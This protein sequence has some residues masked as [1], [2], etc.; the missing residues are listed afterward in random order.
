MY[1]QLIKDAFGG[2]AAAGVTVGHL[3]DKLS[4][5]N[6]S[7][8]LLDTG[9]REYESQLEMSTDFVTVG[10]EPTHY[11]INVTGDVSGYNKRVLDS[12]GFVD[13]DAV[14]TEC[15]RSAMSTKLLPAKIH[16]VNATVTDCDSQ[17]AFLYNMLVSWFKAYL[18]Q[19]RDEGFKIS[20]KAFRDNHLVLP[21]ANGCGD[22]TYEIKLGVPAPTRSNRTYF[23]Q[24]DETNFWE[25]PYVVKFNARTPEQQAFYLAHVLGRESDHVLNVEF[26]IETIP[27]A[28]TLFESIGEDL[29]E[30]VE[31][32]QV[33]WNNPGLLHMWIRDYVVLNRCYVAYAAA[34]DL[35]GS[36][37][38]HP[39]PSF[40]ESMWWNNLDFCVRLA[41]FTPTRA[42]IPNFADGEMAMED[43]SI[44][45]FFKTE[46]ADLETFLLNS[47]VVNYAVWLG[48]YAVLENSSNGIDDWNCA[49][50]ATDEST[51]LM[52]GADTRA[53]LSSIVFDRE[54]IS[55]ASRNC[56]LDFDTE[57]MSDENRCFSALKSLDGSTPCEMEVTRPVPYVSGALLMGTINL[58]MECFRHLRAQQQ[59]KTTRS[60]LYSRDHLL[61]IANVYRLFG[62]EIRAL[63][64]VGRRP[65]T[66]WANR[67][68]L[69]LPYFD[70][71][72]K[73]DDDDKL[74][75][76]HSVRRPG[77][78][79][80]ILNAH[81]LQGEELLSV[82][83]S[84][85]VLKIT[86]YGTRHERA[87]VLTRRQERVVKFN[88]KV[89]NVNSSTKRVIRGKSRKSY[90][91]QDFREAPLDPR[92]AT[93]VG[94][95]L[96][97]ATAYDL[98]PNDIEDVDV[99][100]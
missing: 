21:M 80:P 79:D 4:L 6:Y 58:E 20:A 51:S 23:T 37:A 77:R 95:V 26:D 45:E 59:I 96:D 97:V 49:L 63:T 3:G 7:R 32:G 42:R 55:L 47:A 41:P 18:S 70:L 28:N 43:V 11:E 31:F 78:A 84:R 8:V 64:A 17:E 62:H 50:R 57:V 5:T 35:L 83:I 1:S 29:P 98:N 87:S 27:V 94:R 25:R 88:P 46:A 40:H 2:E 65:L 48:L 10:L 60:G 92:A 24:R 91:E 16:N 81:F 89:R 82:S 93:P 68:E 100:G 34:L 76:K 30:D 67:R 13:L 69:V 85:P 14:I 19:G 52:Q 22:A 73:L 33:P 74:L 54:V 39:M 56:Y 53:Q 71:A 66:L 90:P 15:T 75:L 9:K 72:S 61:Q 44:Y 99:V 12:H 86:D 38:Y 36:L